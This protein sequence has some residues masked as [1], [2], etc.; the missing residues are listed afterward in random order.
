[1]GRCNDAFD[2][3]LIKGYLLD[4]YFNAGDPDYEQRQGCE[5]YLEGNLVLE[6]EE[7]YELIQ[8]SLN[9]D[10]YYSTSHNYSQTLFFRFYSRTIG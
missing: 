7:I 8:D 1:M 2:N 10:N 3:T 9:E 4:K 5:F 6:N